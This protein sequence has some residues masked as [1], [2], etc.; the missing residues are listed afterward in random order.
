MSTMALDFIRW[1]HQS[2]SPL[3]ETNSTRLMNFGRSKQGSPRRA[4]KTQFSALLYEAPLGR[5]DYSRGLPGI[6]LVAI[7]PDEVPTPA[8]FV[9]VLAMPSRRSAAASSMTPPSEVIRPP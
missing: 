1:D 9:C 8:Q 6:L 4:S 7:V 3:K 5:R 2:A